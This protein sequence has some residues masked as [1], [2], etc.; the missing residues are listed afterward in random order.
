M[1]FYNVEADNAGFL[2]QKYLIEALGRSEIVVFDVG[3][4]I[5]Q[6]IDKYREIFPICSVYSF[7]PN[8]KSFALLR[9]RFEAESD[10]WCE[11]LALGAAKCTASFYATNY[12]EASSLLKPEEF[13]SKRSTLRNYDFELMEVSVDTLDLV[14]Q[15]LNI[16]SI[17][18]LK[19][20]VQGTELE[21]LRGAQ[22]LLQE[23]R[24][25]IIYSEVL[26][27]ENYAGQ[28]D[29]GDIWNYLKQFGYV[30]WDVYPFLHTDLGR[31][32]TGNALF[33]SPAIMKRID[34]R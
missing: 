13:V 30:V 11:L 10:V 6:S 2:K 34:P 1:S 31:L 14:A 22:M 3:G 28:C 23:A 24:I 9:E 19:V 8:P 20:D 7:E 25:D 12:P 32:W 29:F 33:V 18:I 21:V 26:F 4:N 16:Q 27:A 17:D 15:R 5:G